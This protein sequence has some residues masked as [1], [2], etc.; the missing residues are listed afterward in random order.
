[1]IAASD[2]WE[3]KRHLMGQMGELK[4]RDNRHGDVIEVFWPACNLDSLKDGRGGI[5]PWVPKA[6]VVEWNM[7]IYTPSKI[8]GGHYRTEF[9]E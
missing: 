7:I 4:V 8:L 5:I 9:V 1:M 6:P 2:T 3:A